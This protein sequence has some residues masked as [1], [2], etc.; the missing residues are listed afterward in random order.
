LDDLNQRLVV[1]GF[2]ALS[3]T[4]VTGAF[5]SS[6][7]DGFFWK[8][9]PKEIA[10]LIAWFLFGV[11]ICARSIAGWQGKRVAVLT[12]AGFGALIVSFISSYDAASRLGLGR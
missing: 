2:V 5:F 6:G 10:T 3:T 1:W 9:E 11:L 8:W 4:L 12:M 7:G